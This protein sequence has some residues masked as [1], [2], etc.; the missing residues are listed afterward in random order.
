MTNATA[1]IQKSDERLDAEEP[2]A[3]EL[4][5]VT[6]RYAA[7]KSH[8]AKVIG[9]LSLR[10]GRGERVALVGPNGCGKSTVINL[11]S[12]ASTPNEGSVAWFG[13]E[14]RRLAVSR[15]GVVFQSPALD[16]LL[17]ARETLRLSS[18]LLGLD[19]K[20]GDAR[21]QELAEK[22]GFTDRLDDRIGTLSGGLIRR[23]DLA[24]AILH[25]PKLLLLDEPTGG[26]DEESSE[27]FDEM[28]TALTSS[29]VAV[30]TAT[31]TLQEARSADRLVV[32]IEGLVALDLTA[33]ERASRFGGSSLRVY[34][35]SDGRT[36]DL[37][38][39]FAG[40]DANIEGADGRIELS[41]LNDETLAHIVRSVPREGGTV[42]AGAETMNDY[43]VEAKRALG[44]ALE[45]GGKVTP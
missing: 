40:A 32:M 43:V 23:V 38:G 6:Y 35:G 3:A 7:R 19:R 16:L 13:N 24:R 36:P 8:K 39:C 1:A 11:L 17:T 29:G 12:G 10:I 26:L 34:P 42:Q 9:P 27:S 2:V 15:V 33:K 14:G 45:T 31:H 41:R 25:Q 18:R 28:I 21:A 22:L 4:R 20:T 44:D 30:V 37:A 5:N